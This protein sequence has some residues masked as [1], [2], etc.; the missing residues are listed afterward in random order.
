MLAALA[1]INHPFKTHS[2]PI[3]K[4]IVRTATLQ[5]TRLRREVPGLWPK[6]RIWSQAGQDPHS[7]PQS[8][9]PEMAEAM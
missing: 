3:R 9:G 7:H 1:L 8:R 4:V 2:C 6:R 5:M